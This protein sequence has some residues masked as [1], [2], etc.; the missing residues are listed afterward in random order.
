MVDGT[1]NAN[2][3]NGGRSVLDEDR[4]KDIIRFLCHT[5]LCFYPAA[6][7]ASLPPDPLHG[8]VPDESNLLTEFA[9]CCNSLAVTSC[10]VMLKLGDVA[11]GTATDRTSAGRFDSCAVALR[12][13]RWSIAIAKTFTFL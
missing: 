13:F 6:T 1:Q 4:I 10:H 12:C 7:T 11:E 3:Y 5:L 9:T 8:L 2:S